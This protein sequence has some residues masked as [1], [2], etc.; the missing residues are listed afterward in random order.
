M[1]IFQILVLLKLSYYLSSYYFNC[2]LINSLL[3]YVLTQ[4]KFE[5]CEDTL[6]TVITFF[7]INPF[8]IVLSFYFGGVMDLED[9]QILKN[10]MISIYEDYSNLFGSTSTN[11]LEDSHLEKSIKSTIVD[12]DITEI[13]EKPL[14]SKVDSDLSI[15]KSEIQSSDFAYLILGCVVWFTVGVCIF[16]CF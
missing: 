8:T 5:F 4:S 15:D 2:L 13:Q 1:T 12:F 16:H 9:L 14:G 10:L 7:F 3:S 11:Y 6:K